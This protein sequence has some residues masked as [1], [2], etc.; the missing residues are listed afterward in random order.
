MPVPPVVPVLPLDVR[1][2]NIASGVFIS[3]FAVL[4]TLGVLGW[5]GQQPVFSLKG[6][7]IDNELQH[8]NAVTL[9]ANV[10]PKLSGN[11]FTLNLAQARAAFEAV[12][13]VRQAVVRREFPDRLRVGL[14]E[15]KAVAFWGAEPDARLVNSYGEVFEVNQGD[16]EPD[17]L[18]LLNGPQGQAALVLQTYGLVAPL[19]EQLDSAVA[20]LELTGRGG[21]R[22]RLEGGALIEMGQGTPAE[23][24]QRV[25]RLVGTVTQTASHFGRDLESADLRYAN[26]YAI[27]LRGVTT[28]T[29]DKLDKK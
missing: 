27:K 16:V 17:E 3:G 26:G 1:L 5:L 2:M 7:R 24:A 10:A 8:N 11:F 25:Q 15:H 19:F 28:L 14:Q 6:I 29:T 23:I 22:T 21:W 4:V 13:W 18:P 12:P 20:Q 9:R